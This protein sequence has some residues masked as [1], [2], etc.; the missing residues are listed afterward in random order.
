MGGN[1]DTQAGSPS[2]AV[3]RGA[4]AAI[5]GTGL[6]P[7]STLQVFVPFGDESFAQLPSVTVAD[8]GSFVADVMFD[9]VG[10]AKPF[11]IGA[12]SLQLS[13]LDEDGSETIIDIPIVIEQPVA[14]PELNRLTG[15]Q[16][17]LQPGQLL[18]FNAGTPETVKLASTPGGSVVTGDGWSFSV[19]GGANE[20]AGET[21]AFAANAPAAVSGAGFMA[22]TRADVWLFS[23]PT[24]L[25]SVE[26]SADGTFAA[27]FVIDASMVPSG[28]HTLQ[29]QG[30]G[31]DGYVRAASLGVEVTP[32]VSPGASGSLE[33][34]RGI[35][36]WWIL[37]VMAT[38]IL[39]AGITR[40][41]MGPLSGPMRQL[42]LSLSR[43]SRRG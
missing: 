19:P 15:E 40:A 4:S 30:V 32:D 10:K 24:L 36:W 31:E 21:L 2:V 22:G 29:I 33:Q 35:G 42:V 6:R 5:K 38:V 27:D 7:G 43:S 17:A 8:D 20:K 23:T 3:E 9:G 26:V 13:G 1:V 28:E 18:A 37:G 12:Y 11:P 16:P 14:A 41:L 39:L 25:G 34:P